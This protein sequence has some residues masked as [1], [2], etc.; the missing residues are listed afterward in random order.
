MTKLDGAHVLITGGSEGI[1]LETAR[2]LLTCGATVTVLSRSADKLAA[3]AGEVPGIRT[4]SGDVTDEVALSAAV[5][6]LEP[7]DVL[8]AAAG[9]AEPGHFLELSSDSLRS[10]LDVNYLGSLH[11]VRA[12][13]PGMLERGHGHVVLVS[14]VAAL[15][16]V[17]GYG[18]YSP[19][20]AALVN[21][22]DVLTAEYADRGLT[23]GVLF[24][25]DTITPG[26]EREN[27]T[28]PA[29][30]VAVSASIKPLPAPVVA[31]A[32][33]KGIEHNRRTI[34]ADPASALLARATSVF[35]PVV[36]LSMRRTVRK[37]RA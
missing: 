11:A 3:A 5:A 29:E 34:T 4:V 10:Q 14:S 36:R 12:V 37:T 26:F 13:L 16:G 1:G 25:P 21:L 33:V 7:V 27:V 23:V 32:L 2:L 30:T 9:G 19:A 24:P 8:I 28:K 18:G 35:A 6:A 15:C 31:R 20:K 17:F 22:A